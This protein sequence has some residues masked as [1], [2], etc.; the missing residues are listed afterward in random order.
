MAS[1]VSAV[2]TEFTPAAGDFIASVVGGTAALVRKNSSG[3]AF[4][5]VG[6]ISNAGVIVSNPIAGAVYKFVSVSGSPTVQ[7]DQ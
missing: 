6:R 7:S 2:D 5:E 4:A 3:T 1:L